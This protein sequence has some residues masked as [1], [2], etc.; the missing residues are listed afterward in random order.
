[1]S[2]KGEI[3]QQTK[4]Q[5][6]VPKRYSVIM[7]ND[8]YTP[9]DFVVQV[10]MEIFNKRKEEAVMLMMMVHKGGKAVVGMYAYDIALTKIRL[11]TALAEEEG[12]PFR[13]TVEEQR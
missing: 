3:R 10:L 1:M 4:S 2:T 11:V 13:L 7:H 8:D 9:M 12:Y 5:V 6:R